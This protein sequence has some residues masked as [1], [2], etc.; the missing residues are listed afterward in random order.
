MQEERAFF[1]SME[2]YVFYVLISQFWNKR[3]ETW[4]WIAFS[5]LGLIH[6]LIL[7]LLHIPAYDGPSLIILPFALVDGL[8]MYGALLWAEKQFTQRDID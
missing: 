8:I 4:F 1:I 7:S 5:F 6:I 3:R 2:L